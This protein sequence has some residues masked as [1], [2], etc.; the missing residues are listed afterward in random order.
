MDQNLQNFINHWLHIHS[1]SKRPTT[2]L[3]DEEKKLKE[4]AETRIIQYMDDHNQPYVRVQDQ[5]G[6]SVYLI[7]K[8][9]L[10]KAPVNDEFLTES[11]ATFMF[12]WYKMRQTQAPN[13]ELRRIIPNIKTWDQLMFFVFPDNIPGT[14]VLYTEHVNQRRKEQGKK[15]RR[16]DITDTEPQKALY[17]KLRVLEE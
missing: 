3:T 4:E 13:E 17:K 5:T 16:L 12:Q 2:K 8:D 14:S 15:K 10:V 1:R 6:K 11:F 9:E 7:I